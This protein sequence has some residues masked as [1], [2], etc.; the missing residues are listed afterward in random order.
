MSPIRLQ[1]IIDDLQ[2]FDEHIIITPDES[3]TN[4]RGNIRI[5]KPPLK[6]IFNEFD[7]YIYTPTPRHFDCSPRLIAECALFDKRVEYYDIDYFD[8]GLE[9]RIRDIESGC[10]W[11]K[12]DDNII[13]I[14]ERYL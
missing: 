11:L 1:E 9:T 4:L 3:Y 8:V 7:T 12:K 10:V 2:T 13:S 6:N 5:V 14:M